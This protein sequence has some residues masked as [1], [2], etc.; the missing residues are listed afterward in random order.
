VPSIF[1][2][3]GAPT[4]QFGKWNVGLKSETAV[5]FEGFAGIW[6]GFKEFSANAGS[7]TGFGC[8]LG[9]ST[10]LLGFSLTIVSSLVFTLADAVARSI[11]ASSVPTTL[12]ENNSVSEG[13]GTSNDSNTGLFLGGS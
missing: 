5:G 10:L 6:P 1:A 9:T 12:F 8:E 11:A 2:E 3:N 4:L 7:E 13:S